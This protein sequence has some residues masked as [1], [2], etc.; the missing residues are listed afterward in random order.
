[1]QNEDWKFAQTVGGITTYYQMN[2]NG[3][4]R[5]KIEG[6]LQKSPVFDMVR[7]DVSHGA[8][9]SSNAVAV[10]PAQLAVLRQADLYNKWAPFMVESRIIHEFTKTELISW[11]RSVV[12]FV[13]DRSGLQVM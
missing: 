6:R 3:S 5:V 8:F 2:P 9:S 4:V 1:M 7:V 12:P 13:W 10:L 11:Y